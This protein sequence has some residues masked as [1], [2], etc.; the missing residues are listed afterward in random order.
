AS[1]S[2]L[3]RR[4]STSENLN[5]FKNCRAT[6]PPLLCS[7]DESRYTRS[8]TLASPCFWNV[9]SRCRGAP[10]H[11]R[12]VLGRG[13]AAA[14]D[15][16]EAVAETARRRS[17]A[18][19]PPRPGHSPATPRPLPGH[20]AA[21]AAPPPAIGGDPSVGRSG[22]LHDGRTGFSLVACVVG[23]WS[24][25]GSVLTHRPTAIGEDAWPNS[26]ASPVRPFG[27]QDRYCSGSCGG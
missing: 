7:G 11:P 12:A 17:P 18:D 6:S 1:H 24:G 19:R 21:E 22:G 4:W 20:R 14:G 27:R 5:R 3:S 26:A 25:H 15:R 10:G 16:P 23:A 2:R 8:Q 13:P 9:M